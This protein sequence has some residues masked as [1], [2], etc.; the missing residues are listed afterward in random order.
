MSVMHQAVQTLILALLVGAM[1]S[2]V[3]SVA[4]ADILLV[5]RGKKS[6]T[7]PSL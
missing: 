7:M 4:R 1:V 3:A 5:A 6:I 2:I